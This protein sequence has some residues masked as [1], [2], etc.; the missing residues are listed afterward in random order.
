[1]VLISMDAISVY[2][3]LVIIEIPGQMAEINFALAGKI[4]EIIVR[5]KKKHF[6]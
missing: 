6:L 2:N 3:L 5:R 1:M 4:K